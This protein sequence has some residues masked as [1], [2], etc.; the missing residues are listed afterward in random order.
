MGAVMLYA[1]GGYPGA[2]THPNFVYMGAGGTLYAATSAPVATFAW[3]SQSSFSLCSP[4]MN[5]SGYA[6]SVTPVTYAQIGLP[7]TI[8]SPLHLK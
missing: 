5:G 6:V 7:A 1:S 4:N 3:S 2:T 8:A